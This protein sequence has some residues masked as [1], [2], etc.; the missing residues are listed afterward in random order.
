MCERHQATRLRRLPCFQ[1]Y[2]SVLLILWRSG[3]VEE[4]QQLRV[5][6]G[7]VGLGSQAGTLLGEAAAIIRTV[8]G[9]A[10]GEDQGLAVVRPHARVGVPAGALEADRQQADAHGTTASSLRGFPRRRARRA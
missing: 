5:K 6:R 9:D 8:Q 4:V 10:V 3:L 7:L 1:L 2:L